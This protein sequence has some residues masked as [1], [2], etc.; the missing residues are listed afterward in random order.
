M[1]SSGCFRVNSIDEEEME[2]LPLVETESN[3]GKK[4]RQRLSDDIAHEKQTLAFQLKPKVICFYLFSY[5]F[6]T[7]LVV[8]TSNPGSS[9]LR[10]E[11]FVVSS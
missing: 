2:K 3:G 5:C 11:I 6:A 8:A 10:Q 4:K 7:K 9:I 1:S